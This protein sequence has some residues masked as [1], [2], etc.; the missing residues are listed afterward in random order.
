M[1]RR[2]AW[3][4]AC[5]SALALAALGM[6]A[7]CATDRTPGDAPAP[8]AAI[9][10]LIGDA[11][12]TADAQCHSIGIGAKP[13]G[14]PE[15]Y[16]AWS[17]LRTDGRALEQAV[18]RH[19]QARRRESAARGEMSTCSVIPD[20]GAHCAAGVCRLREGDGSDVY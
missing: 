13:C 16:V 4:P 3:L 14:G 10:A 8:L 7:A 17:S 2:F 18:Q 15:G 11:A 9:D 1:T 20:P 6:S 12:C 5:R 19:A